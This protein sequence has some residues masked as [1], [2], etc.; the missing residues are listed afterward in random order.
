MKKYKGFTLIEL[1]VVIA[2]IA[3]LL[4]IL[5]PSLSLAKEAARQVVCSA[6]VSQISKA[7]IAY[8]ASWDD[9]VIWEDRDHD[10]GTKMYPI[11]DVI[12]HNINHWPVRLMEQQFVDPDTKLKIYGC[13][14]DR[15]F[16]IFPNFFY[17]Q[18]NI[19]YGVSN[20]RGYGS[21]PFSW[22]S[23]NGSRPKISRVKRPSDYASVSESGI[24]EFNGT[25][26]HLGYRILNGQGA[27]FGYRH[28]Y[29]GIVSFFDGH[30]SYMPYREAMQKYCGQDFR[31]LNPD[32]GSSFNDEF[33]EEANVER[34]ERYIVEP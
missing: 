10:G 14:S 23:I 17:W 5:M 16:K 4:S 7:I 22:S 15:G 34:L 20:G 21:G 12:P 26:G 33:V 18:C 31:D 8:A 13:P 25:W 3:L 28:K 9:Q 30:A 19:S 32:Y 1:L 11:N 29:G 27:H 6:G 24:H 2:I